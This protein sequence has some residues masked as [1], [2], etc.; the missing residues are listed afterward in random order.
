MNIRNYI[1]GL[2]A[3]VILFM[4]SI[5]YKQQ[6][7]IARHHFPIPEGLKKNS[8]EVP[9]YLFL[10][11][12]K[13]DCPRCVEKL[14]E[15]LKKLPS[16]FCTVGIAPGEELKNESD[17]RGLVGSSL[18]LYNTQKFEKYIPWHTPTLIGVSQSGKI[19]F[20]FP[21]IDGQM[22]YLENT[23]LSIYGK[24]SPFDNKNISKEDSNQE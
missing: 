21:G 16:H 23:I 6:N 20:V 4:G 22:D 18:P 2:L 19:I 5:I 7:T 11:F 1:I 10:F 24:L 3:V 12:S 9:F 8:T 14:V 13:N 15:V 17:L